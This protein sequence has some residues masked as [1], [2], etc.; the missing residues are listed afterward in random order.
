MSMLGEPSG[1]TFFEVRRK[2]SRRRGAL[3]SLLQAAGL[4]SLEELLGRGGFVRSL[5]DIQVRHCPCV[6]AGQQCVACMFDA[7]AEAAG[8]HPPRTPAVQ[9]RMRGAAGGKAGAAT[10]AAAGGAADAAQ[11]IAF[12]CPAC[13]QRVV[14]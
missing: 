12:T 6:T 2:L 4:N 3:L 7:S 9:E 1:P 14:E 8:V 5:G 10:G 11:A 13:H